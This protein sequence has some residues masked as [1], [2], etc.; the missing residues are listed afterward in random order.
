MLY[1]V[2]IRC[3][4][5]QRATVNTAIERFPDARFGLAAKR[6]RS[7]FNWI[8]FQFSMET[9]VNCLDHSKAFSLFINPIIKPQKHSHKYYFTYTILQNS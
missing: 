8:S 7:N 5:A 6:I 2:N 3:Q 9:V 4:P 1:F